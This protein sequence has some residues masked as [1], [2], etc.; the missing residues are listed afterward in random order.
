MGFFIAGMQA[1]LI[2][3]SAQVYP[4]VMRS[5]G[6]GAMMAF[7]RLG[8]LASSITGTVVLG[9][10]SAQ[11]LLAMGGTILIAGVASLI[12]RSRAASVR[13]PRLVVDPVI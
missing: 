11:F 4:T 6:M 1:A 5:T 13:P 9:F 10:G 3:F 12:A 2:A 7:G 8:A